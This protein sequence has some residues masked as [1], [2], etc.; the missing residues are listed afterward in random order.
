LLAVCSRGEPVAPELVAGPLLEDLARCVHCGLCSQNC[1]TYAETGLETESPRG[2]LYLMRALAEGRIAAT[3]N[4]VSHMELC[5]LC[6]N[7]E[8]VCPS[9]V[10][11][12]R[13]MQAQRA[14]LNQA[15]RRSWGQR[16]VRALVFRRLMPHPGRLALLAG[17][18]RVYQRSGLQRLVRGTRVLALFPRLRQMESLL[19]AVPP[20]PFKAGGNPTPAHG[21]EVGRVAVFVGCVM[22]HLYP[23]VHR[24]MVRVLA[25]NGYQVSAPAQ[26]V[27]CGSLHEHSGEA[28]G[29]A[30]LARRNIVAFEAQGDAL[31]VVNAAGCGATLKEYD[32]LLAGDPEF[33]DRA[34]RF[35]ERVVDVSELIDRSGLRGP[36][37]PV[38]LRVTYQDSCHLAHAQ[39]VTKVPRALIGQVPGVELCEMHLPDRCCGSAGI[40]NITQADFSARLLDNKMADIRSTGAAAVVTANPGCML[41]LRAGFQ[42]AETDGEVLHLVELLDRAYGGAGAQV[43]GKQ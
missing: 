10:P 23:E 16:L 24:A 35:V 5:L 26:Q 30:E 7:C 25:R 21:P 2:R 6:R 37:R 14:Q 18:L 9:G 1:P 8:A 27:C 13:I 39:R 4:F 40:Y 22:P 19:P 12:G 32:E 29:A 43:P 42:R 15:A 31:I 34:T 11:F 38:N 3:K 20:R 33:R 41:Q 36:L 28:A 17:L